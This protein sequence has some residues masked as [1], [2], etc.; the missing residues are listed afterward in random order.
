LELNLNGGAGWS[1]TGGPWIT[2]ELSC[3]VVWTGSL[4]DG[5]Q[6]FSGVLPAPSQ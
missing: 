3:K 1:G 4:V 5:G 6:Q 2:P